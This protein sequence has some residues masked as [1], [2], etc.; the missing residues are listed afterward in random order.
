MNITLILLIAAVICTVIVTVFTLKGKRKPVSNVLFV[1]IAA[2]AVTSFVYNRYRNSEVKDRSTLGNA[3]T[4]NVTYTETE[5]GYHYFKCRDLTK[6]DYLIAISD[7]TELPSYIKSVDEGGIVIVWDEGPYIKKDKSIEH[8]GMRCY[9][10]KKPDK[11][12]P[13]YKWLIMCVMFSF[14][15]VTAVS[16]IISAIIES[17]SK[18]QKSQN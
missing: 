15:G 17:M 3:S 8:D 1:L 6:S 18:K 13:N 9:I 16:N 7:K 14:V 2:A 10:A 12:I 4:E 11:I 5:N